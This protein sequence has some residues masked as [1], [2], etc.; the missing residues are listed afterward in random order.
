MWCG[1]IV[2]NPEAGLRIF[3][4]GCYKIAGALSEHNSLLA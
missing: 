2:G 4:V 3:A 1:Q